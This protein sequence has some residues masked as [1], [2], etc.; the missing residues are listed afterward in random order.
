LLSLPLSL[1]QSPSSSSLTGFNMV[2]AQEKGFFFDKT[3]K[4]L[5][6]SLQL[7]FSLERD[8]MLLLQVTE[9]N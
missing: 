9:L 3:V 2:E 4:K 6:F 1:L 7:H 8:A 5:T